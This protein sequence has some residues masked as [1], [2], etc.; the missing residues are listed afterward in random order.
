[1]NTGVREAM[2]AEVGQARAQ[3]IQRNAWT[4]SGLHGSTSA[5]VIV[6]SPPSFA[7]RQ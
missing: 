7:V 4:Q 3:P 5:A 6:P 1:M 2:G